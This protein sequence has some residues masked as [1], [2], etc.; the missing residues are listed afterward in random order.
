[1]KSAIFS[2]A[3]YFPSFALDYFDE[4]GQVFSSLYEFMFIRKDKALVTCR[5]LLMIFKVE[6]VFQLLKDTIN[7]IEENEDRAPI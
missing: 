6:N 7:I 4:L 3:F 5:L 1:M 2:I